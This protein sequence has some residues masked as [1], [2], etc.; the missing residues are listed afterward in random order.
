MIKIK[1][2]KNRLI[3]NILFIKLSFAINNNKIILIDEN[4]LRRKV[5]KIKGLDVKFEGKNSKIILHSPINNFNNCKILIRS[6]CV[7]EIG[8]NSNINNFTAELINH[9]K[10]IIGKNFYCGSTNAFVDYRSSLIIGNDCMFSDGITI[11]CGDGTAH[12][13]IDLSTNTYKSLSGNVVI[14]DHVW[15]GLN[16]TILKRAH[17]KKDSIIGTSA[18]VAKQF[19]ETN[20]SIAGNPA[21]IIQR[22]INWSS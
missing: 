19:E 8:Q 3:I 7:V 6:N 21:K 18:V 2:I 17:V 11:R 12:K 20:V 9:S 15:V 4:G 10:L 5:K 13:I 1:R 14:E 16:A 22:N